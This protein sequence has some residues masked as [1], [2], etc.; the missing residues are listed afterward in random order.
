M[1][2]WTKGFLYTMGVISTK[3]RL[4]VNVDPSDLNDI[5]CTVIL[6]GLT[7]LRTFS[8][9]DSLTR[10]TGRYASPPPPAIAAAQNS[11]KS[12]SQEKILES[13]TASRTSK[14][15]W[16][17]A[18]WNLND[19]LVRLKQ[20]TILSNPLSPIYPSYLSVQFPGQLGRI[21]SVDS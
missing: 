9:L 13:V 3:Q 4:A 2:R 16:Q 17:V 12:H 7:A 21:D 8:L 11:A 10:K 20:R 5:P 19:Y 6:L 15:Q 18:L 1:T 14:L